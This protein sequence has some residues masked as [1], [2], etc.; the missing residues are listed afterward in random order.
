MNSGNIEQYDKPSKI[1]QNPTTDFVKQLVY[2]QRH[3]C[4]LPDD[5]L[6]DCEFSNVAQIK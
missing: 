6:K 3:I 4:N 5:K 1:L 2:R